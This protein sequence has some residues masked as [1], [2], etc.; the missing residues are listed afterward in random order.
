MSYRKRLLMVNNFIQTLDE[1]MRSKIDSFVGGDYAMD[2]RKILKYFGL[3]S[4]F[5]EYMEEYAA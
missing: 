4:Q 1:E 2:D 3:E 5:E